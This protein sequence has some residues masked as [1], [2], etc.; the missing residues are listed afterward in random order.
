[1][2]VIPGNYYIT[3]FWQEKQEYDRN[4][5]VMMTTPAPAQSPMF[6]H[7]ILFKTIE[8]R[9][10]MSDAELHYFIQ[11]NFIA[12]VNNIF[13]VSS[14]YKYIDAFQDIRFLDAFAD[15]IQNIQYFDSDIAVRC[16]LLVYHYLTRD[17]RQ[18]RSDVMRRMI[19]IGTII[20][21]Q[22]VIRLKKF[23]LP[24]NLENIIMVTR[25]SDFDLSVCVKRVNL[26]LVSS[27]I[28]Y[29]ILDIDDTY[30]VSD[31]SVDFLAKLLMELYKSE[32]WVY[33]LPYFMV[34]VLPD[35]DDGNPQTMWITP[36]IEACDSALN[37]A[38]LKVLDVM[39]DDSAL[40][41]KVL[42]SYAEGYRIMNR[43]RPVR[44]SFQA[45]S[46]DYPRLNSVLRYLENEEKIYVP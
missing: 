12:I 28:L 24:E 25:Y 9:N 10:S 20:N 22:Q 3:K 35:S 15:V 45:I 26:L 4:R 17:E 19:R 33:V 31:Q 1:M 21:R 16:N 43:K 29:Q 7:S 13:D 18:K 14:G 30:E 36:E 39:L 46:E 42:L 11:Y 8:D 6:N 44:F 23:N 2:G 38:V 34:D 32:E 41:R 40:V 37:L 5:K 27:P